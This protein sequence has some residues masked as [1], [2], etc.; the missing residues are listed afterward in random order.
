V[1]RLLVPI[2]AAT[3]SAC[4]GGLHSSAPP[5]QA[6][7]LRAIPPPAQ[8]PLVQ[9]PSLRVM[10]PLPSPGLESERIVLLQP[11]RRLSF[12]AASRWA[13]PLPDVVEAL[14]VDT[15]RMSG[16]WSSVGDSRSSFPADYI[17][18]ITIRRFEAD[19]TQGSAPVAH[20]SLDCMLGRRTDRELIASFAVEAAENASENRLG[21]IVAAFERAANAALATAAEHAATAVRTS[22]GRPPP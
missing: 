1:R 9:E 2:V 3:M 15:F 20:V 18:Q 6:Y 13:A 7:V 16:A 11:D 8:E 12:Y 5:Q 19:T 14:S 10:R 21:A 4:S 22:P 17:L